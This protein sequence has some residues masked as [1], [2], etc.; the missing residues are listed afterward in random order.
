MNIA[1]LISLALPYCTPN[2][3]E[4]VEDC[5]IW[6]ANYIQVEKVVM[7]GLEIDAYLENSIENLPVELSPE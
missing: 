7:P 1:V 4:I 2:K 3:Q 5:T 6:I